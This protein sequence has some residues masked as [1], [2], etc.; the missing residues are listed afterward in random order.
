MFGKKKNAPAKD[1]PPKTGNAPAPAKPSGDAKGGAKAP[2]KKGGLF[3]FGK[4]KAT[5]A[6]APAAGG[7]PPASSGAAPAPAAKPSGGAPPKAPA[8]AEG[9]SFFKALLM[10]LAIVAIGGGAFFA[11]NKFA[12][13][14]PNAQSA[15]APA[16]A[17]ANALATIPTGEAQ[18]AQAI[19]TKPK[20]KTKKTAQA[21]D[22]NA[23][24]AAA[25]NCAGTP[26]FI[27]KFGFD[28]NV[29]F[30]T[31]ETHRLILFAPVPNSDAVA[32]YQSQAWTQIGLVGAFVLDRAG[33]IYLAPSPRKGPGLKTAG[34]QN[35]LYKV[36]TNTGDISK[37][38]TLPDASAATPE[39]V[40]GI[41]GLAYA[42]D[43][44]SLYVSTLA[45][46]NAK[47]EA[48]RIYRVD[49]NLGAV[50]GRL[51]S[52]DA[53]G[54][55]AGTGAKGAQLYFG[56]A[57]TPKLRAVNLDAQGNFQGQ[58]RDISTLPGNERALHLQL[59]SPSAMLVQA[60][61]FNSAN[62]NTPQGHEIRYQYDTAL[63]TWSAVQ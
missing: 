31:S 11:Y 28:N 42:C 13:P 57:R 35:V 48:G 63:D 62:A 2:A 7:K 54:L 18:N 17:D 58:A 34:A 32:K 9:V 61:E 25:T 6:A 56:A 14:A 33:N 45:G 8:K 55:A 51:D 46:S 12:A 40:Y 16:N 23:N 22:A 3:S 24:A 60:V 49:L 20:A 27:S 44:N 38:I 43:T 47:N 37:F 21:T 41:M 10:V 39:N 4:K 30:D 36:D 59:T 53:L 26:K 15:N 50:A 19:E 29:Y 5:A 1:A 52:V